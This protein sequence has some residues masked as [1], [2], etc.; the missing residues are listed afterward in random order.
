MR[1]ITALVW[2][3]AAVVLAASGCG[4]SDPPTTAEFQDAVVV[5]RDRVDF[6]LARI[7]KATSPQ[8]FLD[9]MSEAAETIDDASSDLDGVGAPDRFSEPADRLVRALA[10]LS[11][12]L[13]A[14]AA[15]LGRP[16]LLPNLV[17]GAQG[18]NFESWDDANQAL[19]DLQELGI[20]VDLIERH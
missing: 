8:D 18:I 17:T 20:E 6:A 15:D 4:G 3:L 2:L 13:S 16:E 14:T 19:A 10:Q 12:D 11:V 9:R 1:G 5:T 7:P